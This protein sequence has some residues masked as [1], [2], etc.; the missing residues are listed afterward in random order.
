[1]GAT[2]IRTN[3]NGTGP[4]RTLRVA[5]GDPS[6][7]LD[8]YVPTTRDPITG[9]LAAATIFW[10]FRKSPRCWIGPWPMPEYPRR[11]DRGTIH[12]G[13]RGLGRAV[14]AY[15]GIWLGPS[16]RTGCRD[17]Q[18]YLCPACCT[19]RRDPA[20]RQPLSAGARRRMNFAFANRF[21]LGLVVRKRCGLNT[22]RPKSACSTI[23]RI[24]SSLPSGSE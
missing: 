15:G 3:W 9:Y 17:R 20:F 8:D 6:L 13:S 16:I 10:R 5:A 7:F 12:T 24:T 21:F 11:D 1:M 2:T 14:G 23:R 19:R 18:G 22:G 4:H